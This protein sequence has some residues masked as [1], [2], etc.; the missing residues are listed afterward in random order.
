MILRDY[1][2]EIS[3]KAVKLLQTYKIAYLAMQVRTG[4][5]LTAIATAHKFGAIKILF[6]TKKKAISDIIAQKDEY[7]PSLQIFVTNYEQLGNVHEQ[8]DIVIIDEAHSLGAFPKPTTRTIEM[9]RICVGKP[10]IYLSGTPNPESYSQLYHQFWVSS[11]SPF[12]HHKTF[13]KW[14]AEYV[15]IKKMM[16]NGQSFNDY[17]KA[18]EKMVMECCKH[19]FITYTQEEAGFESFVNETIHYLEMRETT[20]KFAERLRIDKIMTNKDGEVVLADTAVKLM[21]KLHQIFS[22]SVIVDEPTRVAKAFDMTKAEYIKE[23]FK[24]Q[25]IA[26]YHKFI[27]ERMAIRYIFGSENLT[28][29]PE[30]FNHRND[31]IFISQ[32]QSGREGVNISTADALVF[33]NIDFSAVSYWQSRARIQTK[34]RVKDANIHWIFSR[35]GI[36]DKIY[37]AVMNKTDYTTNIFK[38]DYI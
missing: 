1:Q 34:D 3:D 2:E 13:Y 36:E 10:I 35:G 25:K 4:K 33:Y 14:A 37:K 24:G 22:G 17:K 12:D 19:L 18:D 30:E 32:I 27:A 23:K 15:N 9:K 31:L 6:I 26:I 28:T 20:Y 7:A 5:T 11:Y 16:I 21:Q 8:F 38:K 29:D